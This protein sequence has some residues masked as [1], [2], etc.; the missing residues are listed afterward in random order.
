MPLSIYGE[1]LQTSNSEEIEVRL[2]SR[3]VAM[4]IAP[5]IPRLLSESI[6]MV[7]ATERIKGQMDYE[8]SMLPLFQINS[9]FQYEGHDKR[10]LPDKVLAEE[11]GHCVRK[12]RKESTSVPENAVSVRLPNCGM[13]NTL[14]CH[15]VCHRG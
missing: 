1:T 9:R 5:T 4:I 8:H 12:T 11:Q 10:K 13:L 7:H 3:C 15:T 2:I 14:R 6:S